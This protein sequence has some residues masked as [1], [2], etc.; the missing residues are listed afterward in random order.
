VISIFPL[1]AILQNFSTFVSAVK[2]ASIIILCV[3]Y[4]LVACGFHISL[5]YC[6][7]KFKSISLFESKEDNCCGSKK[8]SKGC[9]KEKSVAYKVRDNHQSTG[10]VVLPGSQAKLLFT[11]LV[12]TDLKIQ[13]PHMDLFAVPESNAPPFND[14]D[15]VYLLNR[16]FRI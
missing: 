7:G 14:P 8:R 10:K 2:K 1:Y 13:K 16:S 9:C 11:A 5:H 15:P 12:I 6:A 3:F 4:F